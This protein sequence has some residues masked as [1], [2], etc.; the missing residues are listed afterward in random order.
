MS[1]N[2]DETQS[3]LNEDDILSNTQLIRM[4]DFGNEIKLIMDDF[5][6]CEEIKFERSDDIITKHI[7]EVKKLHIKFREFAK[8]H[9]T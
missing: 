4:M 8:N 2:D 6:S 9:W 3:E 7:N 5:K 1:N